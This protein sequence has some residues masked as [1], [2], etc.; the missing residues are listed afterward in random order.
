[1]VIKMKVSFENRNE[2]RFH[3]TLSNGQ[4]IGVYFWFTTFANGHREIKMGMC[5]AHTSRDC[6]RWWNRSKSSLDNLSTG[7]VGLEA[8][9]Y[10]LSCLKEISN[11]CGEGDYI[12]IEPS[13]SKRKSAYRYLERYG[14]EW[15][16]EYGT[17]TWFY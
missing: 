3:N 2:V 7:K 10:A 11:W 15:R 13:D 6:N 14:F 12:A 5:V 16:E 9:R 1:V 8:L 17:Y 4:H